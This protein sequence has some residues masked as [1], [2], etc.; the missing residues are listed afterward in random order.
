MECSTSSHV[1]EGHEMK[2]NYKPS[3]KWVRVIPST[4]A[5]RG[6]LRKTS[7]VEYLDILSGKV[8]TYL[9]TRGGAIIVLERIG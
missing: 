6:P 7:P 1:W 2:S 3:Y 8:H 9:P 5:A 4:Q